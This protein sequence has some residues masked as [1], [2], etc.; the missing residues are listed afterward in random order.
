MARMNLKKVLTV[1]GVL[2]LAA[3]PSFANIAFTGPG[4]VGP[5]DYQANKPVNLG[6]VFT[7]SSA[8]SVTALGF[9]NQS[10]L[11]GPETLGL[12]NQSGTLLA[13]TS[14]LLADPSLDG[15]LFHNLITPVA[16]SAGTY[17]V[18]A[19]VNN[20]PWSYGPAPITAPGIGFVQNDYLYGAG[21]A[22]TPTDSVGSGPSYYGSNFEFT[23]EPG[24][25]GLLALG[26]TGLV[27]VVSRRRKA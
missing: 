7:T 18:V 8:I 5:T 24:F 17:T 1:C 3:V 11:T 14:V 21:L 19:Q 25:Y 27:T 2:V 10:Y 20:N 13:S 12:Y 26:L 9:Y 23:P 22:F 6:D 16:I 4:G 15:Y